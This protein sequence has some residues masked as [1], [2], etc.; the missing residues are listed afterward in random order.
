[1]KNLSVLPDHLPVPSDDG[2]CAHLDGINLP[3]IALLSTSG[4]SIDLSTQTGI[5]VIYFY[6]LIGDPNGAAMPGWNDIPGARGCTPQ[7]CAF[8]DQYQQLLELGVQVFGASSQPLDAQKQAAARL[9]LP[10]ELLNDSAFEFANALQLPTF[11]Y[12]G[13]NL[14][15]RLTLIIDNGIIRKVFYPV[16]PPDKNAEAVID[17]LQSEI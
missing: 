3:S 12:N 17:W 13:Q 16:F 14:I 10:F 5:S 4:R 9:H 6:P 15:K 11:E 1:M 8:R 7:S 2:A